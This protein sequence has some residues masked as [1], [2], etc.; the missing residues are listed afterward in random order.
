[1]LCVGR[2]HL[3]QASRAVDDAVLHLIQ[4]DLRLAGHKLGD[5]LRGA[6]RKPCA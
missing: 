1:M 2:S 5:L 4:L 3:A 6:Q